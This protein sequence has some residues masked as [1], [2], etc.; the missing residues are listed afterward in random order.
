MQFQLFVKLL[1]A[2]LVQ[3]WR[4][5][6]SH[7]FSDAERR[8]SWTPTTSCRQSASPSAAAMN[9]ISRHCRQSAQH[10]GTSTA[11]AEARTGTST[12]T[13]RGAHWQRRALA[14]RT[15]A[16]K[17]PTGRGAHWQGAH[18]QRRALAEA[19]ALLTRCCHKRAIIILFSAEY[20]H[21]SEVLC[22]KYGPP[23]SA[24]HLRCRSAMTGLC[25]NTADP[26]RQKA[27]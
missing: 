20:S 10:S 6:R 23:C 26:Q 13:A 25:A 5:L 27:E 4:A 22:Y 14:E 18:W 7:A 3:S 11:L 1:A 2:I 19:R 17:Q 24:C 15:Q 8:K 21:G 16:T 9:F 12:A